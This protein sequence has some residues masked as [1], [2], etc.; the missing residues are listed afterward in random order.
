MVISQQESLYEN[1]LMHWRHVR[2]QSVD[3]AYQPISKY[4]SKIQVK[5]L[6]ISDLRRSYPIIDKH[7]KGYIAYIEVLKTFQTLL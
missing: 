1:Q 5:R 3:R 6:L 7:F 2:D 4:S